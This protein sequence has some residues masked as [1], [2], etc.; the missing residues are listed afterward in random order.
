M[1]TLPSGK[2]G[3]KPTLYSKILILCALA[4]LFVL[5]STNTKASTW[6]PKTDYSGN[7][8]NLTIPGQ[9]P[10]FNVTASA[11]EFDGIN[12]YLSIQTTNTAQ[13]TPTYNSSENK[14]I[15][16]WFRHN[17]F[18]NGTKGIFTDKF[19]FAS[20]AGYTVSIGNI[21][22]GAGINWVVG[23]SFKQTNSSINWTVG[24]WH[25][26]KVT[27][28]AS[29]GRGYIWV[30]GVLGY[31]ASFTMANST[32]GSNQTVVGSQ[33]TGGTFFDGGISNIQLYNRTT[34]SS[35][36]S[37]HINNLTPS[38]QNLILWYPFINTTYDYNVTIT[39]NS[40]NQI[41]NLTNML[42]YQIPYWGISNLSMCDMGG[43]SSNIFCNYWELRGNFTLTGSNVFRQDT[44]FANVI[45]WN[46]TSGSMYFD[47][48]T[49]TT[50]GNI[51]NHWNGV[52]WAYNNNKKTILT[53][54]GTPSFVSNNTSQCSYGSPDTRNCEP[55]YTNNLYGEMLLMYLDNVTKNGTWAD[56]VIIEVGNEM[57]SGTFLYNNG[58]CAERSAAYNRMYNYTRG[59]IHNVTRYSRIPFL[60]TTFYQD[61][62]CSINLTRNFYGNFSSSDYESAVIHYY[63]TYSANAEGSVESVDNLTA[64]I[65]YTPQSFFF[66]ELNGNQPSI[67]NTSSRWYNIDLYKGKTLSSLYNMNSNI[68]VSWYSF[69]FGQTYVNA[70]EYPN[71]WRDWAYSNLDNFSHYNITNR[72]QT[73]FPNGITIYNTS[74]N[75]GRAY[76][77]VGKYGSVYRGMIGNTDSGNA[78]VTFNIT[79]ISNP[80]TLTLRNGTTYNYNTATGSFN[81]IIIPPTTTEFFNILTMSPVVANYTVEDNTA[82]NWTIYDNTGN[83]LHCNSENRS[84]YNTT[85]G[86]I[87]SDRSARNGWLCDNRSTLWNLSGVW[88]IQA[89]FNSTNSTQK[90]IIFFWGYSSGNNEGIQ[91]LLTNSGRLQLNNGSTAIVSGSNMTYAN[92]QERYIAAS[93]NGS[94]VTT[95]LGTTCRTDAFTPTPIQLTNGVWIGTDHAGNDFNG[96]IYDLSIES[97]SYTPAELTAKA[98]ASKPTGTPNATISASFSAVQAVIPSLGLGINTGSEC[99]GGNNTYIDTDNDGNKDTLV[100]STEVRERLLAMGVKWI[101][102]DERLDAF[103]YNNF[104]TVANSNGR[105]MQNK[106]SLAV[107][108]IQNNITPVFVID[109]MPSEFANKT[110]ECASDNLTCGPAN[111]EQFAAYQINFTNVLKAGIDSALGIGVQNWMGYVQFEIWNEPDQPQFFLSS[112]SYFDS[113][114][115]VKYNNMYS[116]LYNAL[117][118]NYTGV[119]VGPS[120]MSDDTV[121]RNAFLGNFSTKAYWVEHHEYPQRTEGDADW[122]MINKS[123]PLITSSCSTAGNCTQ[124]RL[125]EYNRPRSETYSLRTANTTQDQMAQIAMVAGVALKY[126]Y[127]PNLFL[128]T[129]ANNCTLT[130]HN[131]CAFSPAQLNNQL[132]PPYYLMSN[133]SRYF[134]TDMNIST[135]TYGNSYTWFSLSGKNTTN[136]SVMVVNKGTTSG[137]F[138]YTPTGTSNPYRLVNRNNVSQYS[139]YSG[140]SFGALTIAASGVE[141]F[142]LQSDSAGPSIIVYRPSNGSNYGSTNITINLSLSDGG[143]GLDSLWYNNGTANITLNG[144]LGGVAAFNYTNTTIVPTGNHT[145][146][147]Y[148]NDTYGTTTTTTINFAVGTIQFNTTTPSGASANISAGSNQAFSYTIDNPSSLL[149]NTNWYKDGVN[150]TACY[151]ATSCTITSSQGDSTDDFNIT[152]NITASSNTLTRSWTLYVNS[153]AATTRTDIC[154]NGSQAN[155]ELASWM[156]T[157]ALV[158]AAVAVV[159]IISLYNSGSLPSIGVSDL[160]GVALMLIGAAITIAIAASI[161]TSAIC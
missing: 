50:E 159:G 83:N 43:G 90:Q 91:L 40:S 124:K 70:T 155:A 141:F 76:I 132:Y 81:N 20:N 126:N 59:Y 28:D 72:T 96:T 58:T 139:N 62:S 149:T 61:N 80:Y 6:E 15:Y 144:S 51:Y 66:T 11:Y 85:V 153:V 19:S 35:D 13:T 151:N 161:I 75:D 38:S 16:A 97:V 140:G 41:K 71:D 46:S 138:I 45:K 79:G 154:R 93:Y 160:G 136:T 27:Y 42:G 86:G 121:M 48:R 8:H 146:T 25:Y 5:S 112:L 109:K 4:I 32:T 88:T 82:S 77:T 113:N 98:S 63:N 87:Y 47:Q 111:N 145:F 127:T 53:F 107:W 3:D 52:E 134:S 9:A 78:T 157:I 133:L 64:I 34:N 2:T 128:A 29:A 54:L 14:T 110:S 31:N 120:S 36:D 84:Y 17:T 115:T 119:K 33:D 122:F 21:S 103:E 117:T 152:V 147:F 18:P 135:D 44:G 55:Y 116:S 24:S 125:G 142:E 129:E 158:I 104:T 30:D 105:N 74:I 37:N 23:N 100:N 89:H 99:F 73:Y 1:K 137:S 150:Q 108:A 60:T 148:A 39:A 10:T 65:G 101:R 69:T 131:F 118:G 143:S 26:L 22:G 92:N 7:G 123:I 106:I 68:S 102:C 57:Y 95:C 94:H 114:R 49:N 130:T 67:Q 156:P 56:N 12:D